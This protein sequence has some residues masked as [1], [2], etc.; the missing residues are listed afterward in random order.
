MKDNTIRGYRPQ[1]DRPRER[2]LSYD[3]ML[4]TPKAARLLK[5]LWAAPEKNCTGDPDKWTSDDLPTDREAQ[6]LCSGC[7]LL[8][9]ICKEYTE[10]AHPAWG[11][12]AGTVRG[13]KL[14]EVMDDE[15]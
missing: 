10:E 14:K 12:W 4:Q 13:R 1:A 3:Y 15:D 2:E 7:P 5:M 11:V 6:L 8:N 9:N